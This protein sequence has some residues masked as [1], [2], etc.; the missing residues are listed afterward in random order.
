MKNSYL[1]II[2]LDA[3]QRVSQISCPTLLGETPIYIRQEN[4]AQ[5]QPTDPWEMESIETYIRNKLFDQIA[6]LQKNNSEH[7][8]PQAKPLNLSNLNIHID[9]I[10]ENKKEQANSSIISIK[11]PN[12]AK[13]KNQEKRA[14]FQ[15]TLPILAITIGALSS[16]SNSLIPVLALELASSSSSH[17]TSHVLPIIAAIFNSTMSFILFYYSNTIHTAKEYGIE[18]DNYFFKNSIK[19]QAQ[20]DNKIA[21]IIAS[22]LFAAL[23]IGDVTCT[24]L[25]IYTTIFSL[26]TLV[27]QKNDTLMPKNAIIPIAATMALINGCSLTLFESSFAIAGSQHLASLMMTYKCFMKK[28]LHVSHTSEENPSQ[29][30]TVDNIELALELDGYPSKKGIFQISFPI[31]AL[32]IRIL[33]CICSGLNCFLA[34][35]SD[36]H[37][38]NHTIPII[39]AFFNASMSLIQFAYSDTLH[40]AT[41][42]GKNMD[43][44]FF[45]NSRKNTLIPVVSETDMFQNT[46]KCTPNNSEI[47]AYFLFFILVS[48]DVSFTALTNYQTTLALGNLALQKRNALFSKSNLIP[49]AISMTIITSISLS[50]FEASFAIKGSQHVA[51]L[52]TTHKCAR[53]R[54]HVW[55]LV[56]QEEDR[57]IEYADS[58]IHQGS[59]ELI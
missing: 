45:K 10:T 13:E 46:Q 5:Y 40:H 54:S 47:S 17:T 11:P 44:Y 49:M 3:D 33:A 31:I 59:V 20:H 48:G 43:N 32:I 26:A 2:T 58:P 50:L 24:T 30:E 23:T 19:H 34:I 25:T 4:L 21:I 52:L 27:H 53:K 6:C 39:A 8:A 36:P 12:E 1:V 57:E 18:I 51:K 16:L 35:S 9:Y 7:M 55:N 42:T 38:Q 15:K 37:T 14:I 56:R 29:V 28:N 41:E 22:A